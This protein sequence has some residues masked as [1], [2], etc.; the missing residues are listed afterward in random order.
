MKKLY[1]ILSFP[2]TSSSSI[3]LESSL[4]ILFKP[5]S[6]PLLILKRMSNFLETQLFGYCEQSDKSSVSYDP[7]LLRDFVPRNDLKA[8]YFLEW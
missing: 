3:S 8:N 1:L 5:P 2:L 4:A 7:R 6:I